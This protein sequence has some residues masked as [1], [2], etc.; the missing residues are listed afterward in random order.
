[1]N[2]PLLEKDSAMTHDVMVHGAETA[3]SVNRSTAAERMRRHRQCRRDGFRCVSIELP[4]LEVD[5]LVDLA[6]LKQD[7]RNDPSAIV[8]ARVTRNDQCS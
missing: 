8:Q 3:A 2:A 5:C 1:M 6:L 4:E 7:A